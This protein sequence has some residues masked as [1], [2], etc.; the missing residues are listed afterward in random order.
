[1]KH[2][3]AYGTLLDVP[4]M[5]AFAPSAVPSGIMSLDDYELG[6]AETR[7]EGKGGCWLAPKPGA[8]T[9]GLHYELSD[10]DMERMDIASGLPEGLW[11]RKSVT[12]TGADGE[13]F[14]TMT[15]TIP[16]DPPPFR[17]SEG[18]VHAI[19]EGLS[20]LDVPPAY[21]ERVREIV[22]AALREPDR[23]RGE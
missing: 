4:S 6:F 23:P 15:Y 13:R 1:M 17:P 18:Y 19:L 22:G 11:A 9:Y 16:G 2:Y 12:V 21:K 5:Q 14:S 3:F 8:V 20:A 7:C 10:E